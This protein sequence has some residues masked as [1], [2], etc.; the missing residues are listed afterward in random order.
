MFSDMFRES[1]WR[2]TW[3]PI[4]FDPQFLLGILNSETVGED[5]QVLAY[6]LLNTGHRPTP[7]ECAVLIATRLLR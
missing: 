6:N 7:E 2:R 1:D 3:K 5:A 4:R